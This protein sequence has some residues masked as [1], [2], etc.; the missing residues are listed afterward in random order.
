MKN[1]WRA[2][3]QRVLKKKPL[4]LHLGEVWMV[5]SDRPQNLDYRSNGACEN[6]AYLD[7]FHFNHHRFF[8]KTTPF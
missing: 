2:E 4:S 5:E 8:L 6:V 3:T 7:D 1:P